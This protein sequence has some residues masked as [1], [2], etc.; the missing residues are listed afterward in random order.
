MKY[1][2]RIIF[3]SILMQSTAF[4]G[5]VFSPV[6]PKEVMPSKQT[7]E[8]IA[9]WE[10]FSPESRH[11]LQNITLYSGH[12]KESA[13]L[14]PEISNAKRS[15]WDFSPKDKI[16]IA[17]EYRQTAVQL[18]QALPDGTKQ[19]TLSYQANSEFVPDRMTCTN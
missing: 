3:L 18:V 5:T 17:C 16:Y 13:S 2:A 12:P 6:C 11:F 8:A 14:K 4:A 9:G 1:F 19:C 10:A 7:A 15:V